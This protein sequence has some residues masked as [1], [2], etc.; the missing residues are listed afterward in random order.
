MHTKIEKKHA[1]LMFQNITQI[2]KKIHPFKIQDFKQRNMVLYCSKKSTCI[3]ERNNIKT[4]RWFLFF[5]LSSFFR[6]KK[7]LKS[8]KTTCENKDFSNIVM[9][10][11][12]ASFII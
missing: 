1:L 9:L 3:N 7:Q 5:K 10:F 4:P 12:K 11:N 2:A 6:K 8:N